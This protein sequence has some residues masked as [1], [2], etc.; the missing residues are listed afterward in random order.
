L[1]VGKWKEINGSGRGGDVNCFGRRR[2][3]STTWD[4]TWTRG[5]MLRAL[6]E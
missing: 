3:T 6:D 4:R 5:A 2:R 1:G